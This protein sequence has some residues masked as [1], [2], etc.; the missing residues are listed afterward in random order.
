LPSSTG[1][2]PPITWVCASSNCSH[3]TRWISAMRLRAIPSFVSSW[4]ADFC[5]SASST[6]FSVDPLCDR[7]IRCFA[8][9]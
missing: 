3:G 1:V 5:A 6:S 9:W 7:S 8:S 2:K 4:S